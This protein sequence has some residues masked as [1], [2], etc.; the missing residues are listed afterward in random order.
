MQNRY[1]GDIGDYVK[2]AILRA[3]S[4]DQRLGVIWW[5]FQDENHNKDGSH[6][7][8]LERPNEWRHFD[9]E[10]F[11]ELA[12]INGRKEYDVR[13]IENSAVLKNAVFVSD[14]VPCSC[15][16]YPE[17]PQK[18]NQWL[19]RAKE[20][21][22]NCDLLFLDPDNGVASDKLKLT[23][24]CAG[25]SVTMDE[26]VCLSEKNRV[27]VVY[28]HHTRFKGGHDAEIKY[29]ANRLKDAHLTVSGALRAKPWSPRV[30]FILNGE[31]DLQRRAENVAKAWAPHIS[32]CPEP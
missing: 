14:L 9:S 22:V 28:H 31:H 7:K 2:Y 6:R 23:R 32:W 24:R 25:K 26:L 27:I 30:F 5:L 15:L 21:V 10:L 17:R 11:D 3:L 18:R 1:V 4:P 13:A 20:T 16:P 29:L 8:Y 12:R 19:R